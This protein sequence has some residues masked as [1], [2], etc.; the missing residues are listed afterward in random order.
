MLAEMAHWLVTTQQ[1]SGETESLPTD[2]ES[3]MDTV[4]NSASLNWMHLGGRLWLAPLIQ[5]VGGVEAIDRRALYLAVEASARIGVSMLLDPSSRAQEASTVTL[6][7]VYHGLTARLSASALEDKW[8]QA[9]SS[10]PQF[11]HVQPNVVAETLLS[12]VQS[13]LRY[14]ST[15]VYW[16]ASSVLTNV[17]HGLGTVWFWNTVRY[18]LTLGPWVALSAIQSVEEILSRHV[19]AASKRLRWQ[20]VDQIVIDGPQALHVHAAEV[21]Y[22]LAAY[23]LLHEWSADV[24][25][26]DWMK[27]NEEALS[28]LMGR[29]QI[30]ADSD[31]TWQQWTALV[32]ALPSLFVGL[33]ATETKRQLVCSCH[34]GQSLQQKGA[35]SGAT[36]QSTCRSV[37]FLCVATN[38][39]SSTANA[40]SPEYHS[41]RGLA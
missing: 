14:G 34:A 2:W 24:Y 6:Y 21:R 36:R 27:S 12:F 40:C 9:L 4:L 35:N 5:S 38:G 7:V 16:P 13:T 28:S 3:R 23:I 22:L 11:T 26:V 29:I 17:R 1:I 18:S 8:S 19:K 31:C 41:G 15:P 37:Y 20:Q 25:D 30:R 39:Q 10:M 32:E 33:P